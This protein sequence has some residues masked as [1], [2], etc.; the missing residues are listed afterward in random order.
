MLMALPVPCH[1]VEF[2]KPGELLN[3]DHSFF[4]SLVDESGDKE[5]LYNAATAA[6]QLNELAQRAQLR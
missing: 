4:K 3:K 5:A 1:Q 2:D 6:F